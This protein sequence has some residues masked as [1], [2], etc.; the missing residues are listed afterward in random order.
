MPVNAVNAVNPAHD[1][2]IAYGILTTSPTPTLLTDLRC[3]ASDDHILLYF[4]E[5]T[6][7][8]SIGIKQDGSGNLEIRDYKNSSESYKKSHEQKR[9]CKIQSNK[10]L[11]EHESFVCNYKPH[12]IKSSTN[13]K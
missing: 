13:L 1:L 4:T 2:F 11:F 7:M 6:V 3:C 9:I 12:K 10:D 5:N 8:T